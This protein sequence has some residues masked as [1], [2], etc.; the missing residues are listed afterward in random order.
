MALQITTDL[1]LAIAAIVVASIAIFMFI[2]ATEDTSRKEKPK[3]EENLEPAIEPISLNTKS[4]KGYIQ[5]PKLGTITKS[6]QI[7]Q[8]R[9]RIRTLTLQQEILGMV[10]KRLFEAEDEG[11]IS[12][13]ER[14]RLASSYDKEIR[15]VANELHK[16]ELI[17][18]LN[19][20]EEIRS[21]IIE[22]FQETLNDTQKKIDLIIKELDIKEPETEKD[23]PKPKKPPSKPPRRKLPKLTPKSIEKDTEEEDEE[24]EK[25]TTRGDSVEERL[26]KIKEDVLKEL[27][28]LDRLEL[29]T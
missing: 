3:K 18:S 14:E 21:S 20:L 17:V 5:I 19:E 16:A 8:A 29:E 10:M 28:E 22:Q 9:S 4:N 27:E 11:E 26:E 23:L 25:E 13:T 6:N 2:R 15:N 1:I 7:A 12:R 24:K